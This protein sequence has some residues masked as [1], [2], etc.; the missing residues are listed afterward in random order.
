[1]DNRLF[2]KLV[3]IR[4]QLHRHPE[5]GFKEFKTSALI[6][7]QL[8]QLNIPYEQAAV[9]GVIASLKKG[10]GKTVV[11][12]ADM[13][14]LPVQESSGVPFTS[15]TDN[16]MHACGHDVHTT[17]LI[18]AA[19]L[20]QE[21]DFN[22]TVKLV[23]Q[24]SEESNANSPEKGKS[25]GQLMM[26]SGMLD[27][28]T[29]ALGLHLHPLLPTGTLAYHNGEAL[30]NVSNFRI[31]V[32]GKGGHAGA[33]EHA[34]DPVMISAQ[35]INEA[36]GIISHAAPLQAAVLIFTHIESLAAPSF[37]VMPEAVLLQGSL[38]ALSITLYDKLA[39]KLRNLL[40]GL[41][42][43]HG[44]RIELEFTAYYPSLF[45]DATVHEQLKPAQAKVFGSNV[46]EG[47]AQLLGEDFS[48]F[49][50]KMPA[51]FYFL[52]AQAA[53]TEAHFLHHPKVV[54]DENCIP[55]GTR[56]LAEGAVALLN[57]A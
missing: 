44:C 45:N 33:P 50:R 32:T 54:F 52:G 2:E 30:A 48:F 23:F 43:A 26:E 21:T 13:D 38:R 11:L 7:E 8:Q 5:L 35:L 53:A 40:R 4:R 14:A 6:Q 19:H 10:E 42:I 36:Q 31:V 17:M 20:L 9:T 56:F 39:D 41:E 47:P 37:N 22:G 1:M 34:V 55:Y 24:P 51:Q 25:G 15:L 27:D 3:S 29:A 57:K 16:V 46:V 12:R 49:S 18:G 28:A